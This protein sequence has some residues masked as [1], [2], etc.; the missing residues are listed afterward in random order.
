MCSTLGEIRGVL[1]TN[2]E[3]ITRRK[4]PEREVFETMTGI[5]NLQRKSVR[6]EV[7]VWAGCECFGK[8]NKENNSY[9]WMN[10]KLNASTKNKCQKVWNAQNSYEATAPAAT[11]A[12]AN[13]PII[14]PKL[15]CL[16]AKPKNKCTN[17]GWL[18]A[19]RI[20]QRAK[21]QT[22]TK[23]ILYEY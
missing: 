16:Q 10:I 1:K 20:T 5:Q 3:K 9:A 8:R 14:H 11:A 23:N 4:W 13:Q 2:L 17:R 19:M 6:E 15:I 21:N 18:N 7:Y 22:N 12:T